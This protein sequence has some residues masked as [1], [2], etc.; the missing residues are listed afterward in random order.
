VGIVGS[1][2][3]GVAMASKLTMAG[4][5]DFTVFE[6]SAGPG[7]VWWDNVYPGAEVDTE[8]I[9]YSYSFIDYDWRRTHGTQAEL[10]KYTEDVIDH[11][12]MRGHFKFSCRVDA[13][14][15]DEDRGVYE[16]KLGDGTEAEVDILVSAVGMLNEPRIPD[17]PGM[18]SFEGP[19]FHSSRW[20]DHEMSGKRV[21]VIGTGC[22]AAQ[23]VPAIAPLAG[24][25]DLYQREPGWVLPK[26]DRD[27]TPEEREKTMRYW[28]RTKIVRYQRFLAIQRYLGSFTVGSKKHEELTEE[29]MN[30]I[31]SQIEDPELQKLVTPKYPYGCK[32]PIK[33][34]NF[35]PALTRENVS[36]VPKAVTELTPNGVVDSG[37]VERPA[38]I[39][40]L[41]VG[42]R[43]AEFLADL[44]IIGRDGR[45]LK[46]IWNGNPRALAGLTVPG[47]PNFF[48]LYGPNTNG[49]GPMT[50]QQE[51]QAEAVVRVARRMQRRGLKS[52]DTDPESMDK[53]VEW[54]DRQ[55]G[56]RWSALATG[57]NNYFFS[58]TGRNVTQWPLSHL[59]YWWSTISATRSLNG[60]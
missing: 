58:A 37:G 29:C 21:A 55:N 31:R 43:A 13:A 8:S 28:W 5:K 23:I 10:Q 46:D 15:W 47:M 26:E 30:L 49:G 34:S 9:S 7:G 51:R 53:Y 41:A 39:V 38:D 11:F 3:A 24:H 19:L 60:K 33:A 32:R 42:F 50:A 57:C 59:R 36:L 4:F 25:L 1:G 14:I 48:M 20:E 12:G 44:E 45:S 27:F 18:E 17:W 6:R 16:L 54:I 2:L 52:V 40:I 56:E 35:Y 22:T